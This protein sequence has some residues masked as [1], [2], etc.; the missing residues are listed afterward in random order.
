MK[1]ITNFDSLLIN[2]NVSSVEEKEKNVSSSLHITN[3]AFR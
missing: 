1:F 2:A 3:S